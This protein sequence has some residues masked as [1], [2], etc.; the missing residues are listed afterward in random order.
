MLFF[1][2]TT[3]VLGSWANSV[4]SL[5]IDRTLESLLWYSFK[6]PANRLN[7][8]RESQSYSAAT[9]AE[10]ILVLLVFSY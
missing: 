8:K 5:N 4:S 7:A 9:H 2:S 3:S 6:G 10:E 1:G